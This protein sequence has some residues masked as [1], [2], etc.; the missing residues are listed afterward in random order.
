[1]PELR[2]LG[3]VELLV[4]AGEPVDLGPPKQ[5][6]VL[7]VLAMSSGHPVTVEALID[8][9]WG[10]QPPESVRDIVYTYVSRLRRILRQAG[11]PDALRRGDGR[12][13]LDLAPDV[14]DLHR[15]RM[16]ARRA[17][18]ER[19]Q[20]AELLR[21][22]TGLWR[23][24]PLAGLRGDWPARVQAGLVREHV[25]LL[26]RRFD[27][28]L[29]LGRHA[30][31]VEELSDAVVEHPLAEPLAARLMLALYRSG[32][33]AEALATYDST[34]HQLVEAIGEDPG[35]SLRKLHHHILRQDP[36]LDHQCAS[37]PRPAAARPCPLAQLPP[38]ASV[39]T[40][41]ARWPDRRCAGC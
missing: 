17:R 32:R 7:A 6:C 33:R 2:L 24:T 4:E 37:L 30:E 12:Y 1:M 3:T 8:C 28:E 29:E 27:A 26:G 25:T 15:S 36:G 13:L 35:P 21:A 31:V 20:A 10:R 22:A 16:L 18:E 41:P 34:R 9:V 5:R 11:T 14:V 19:E 40:G 39:F 23:G 38:D